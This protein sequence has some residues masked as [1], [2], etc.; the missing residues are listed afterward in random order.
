MKIL[1]KPILLNQRPI[2]ELLCDGYFRYDFTSHAGD[3][4][5]LCGSINTSRWKLRKLVFEHYIYRHAIECHNC[6]YEA[7]I[8]LSKPK[9]SKKI[10]TGSSGSSG[11][12]RFKS[13]TIQQQIELL[14]LI[15]GKE[16]E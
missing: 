8:G 16:T 4:C 1:K 13:L 6:V 11:I 3:T 5:P 14:S 10:P 15:Q 9:K 2:S 12:S 7:I